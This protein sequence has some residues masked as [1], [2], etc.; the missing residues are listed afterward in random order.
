[1]D[2]MEVLAEQYIRKQEKL[3]SRPLRGFNKFLI[4][5]FANSLSGQEIKQSVGV[6]SGKIKVA[7]ITEDC[8]HMTGGRYYALFIANALMEI[9]YEVTVYTNK[10]PVFG[11]LFSNYNQPEFK[12]VGNSPKD[13]EVADILADIY[14]GS[15]ISGNIASSRLGKKYSKPSYALI[16]DPF[17]MMAKYLGEKKYVGWT[18]LINELSASDTK[19]ISLCDTTTPYIYDWLN[20]RQ[21]QVM[22]IYPCINSRDIPKGLE[23][24]KREDYVVFVSR[25]VAHKNFDHVLRACRN[26]GIKLKVISSVDG[27]NAHEM[28][29][30]LKMT[31]QVEFCMNCTDAE[32]FE[33]IA[34]SSGLINASKF[35]GFGMWAIEAIAMGTPLVCYKYPTLEEIRDYA[36]ADNFYMAEWNNER[37]LEEQLDKC[38]KEKKFREHSKLFDFESMVKR[39]NELFGIEPKIGVITIALN[40]EKFINASLKSVIKHPNVKKVA[41]VEGAVNLFAHACTKDGLSL[42]DTDEQVWMAMAEPNGNKIIYERYGWA[43]DKSELRNRALTLLGKGITHVLVV[44]ADEVWMPEEL[45]KLVQA[46][47]DN[48]RNGVF[49]FKLLHFWH[50]KDMRAIGGQWESS[51]FRCFKFEDKSLH[52]GLHQLPVVNSE[53]KFINVTDGS[54]LFEDISVHHYGYCKDEKDVKDKLEFYKKRDGDKLEVKDTWTNWKKG[55]PTQ[56]THGGGTAIKYTGKHPVEI[57]DII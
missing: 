54:I 19:I 11:K 31:K 41:V 37:G 21:D 2:K 46:M 18:P 1:M 26:L 20:K 16:F 52:W 4:K 33:I 56:P 22:P 39:C 45:D 50:S 23:E 7:L 42:D 57:E 13:L 32:K 40:E 36:K 38:I 47:K 53:G 3:Y 43:L 14:I 17:P 34:K 28:V 51:L 10:L 6:I 30:A 48:P 24:V 44:D 49:L 15:P 55:Q 29:R 5:D 9:G 8:N 35:E 25:L 12:V 27:I